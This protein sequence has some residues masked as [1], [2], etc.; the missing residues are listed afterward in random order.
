[1]YIDKTSVYVYTF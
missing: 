1:M